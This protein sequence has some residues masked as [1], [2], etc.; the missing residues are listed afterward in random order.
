MESNGLK[1][2]LP[3]LTFFEIF[4]VVRLPKKLSKLTWGSQL[5]TGNLDIQ[6]PK[7]VRR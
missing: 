5:G 7:N 4:V 1:T 3:F 6:I 2:L